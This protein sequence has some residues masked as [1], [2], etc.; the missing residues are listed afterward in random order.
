ME[1]N[2]PRKSTPCFPMTKIPPRSLVAD[3]QPVFFVRV[4]TSKIMGLYSLQSGPMMKFIPD[5][6]EVMLW[7]QTNRP[8]RVQ[9]GTGM[10]QSSE[11]M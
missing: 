3:R 7:A 4:Q 5:M 1:K 2:E 9:I 6:R 11:T 10:G 8:V